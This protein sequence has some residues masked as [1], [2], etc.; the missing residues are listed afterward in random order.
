MK[1]ILGFT[2]LV[3][4]LTVSICSIESNMEANEIHK[5]A[6]TGDLNKIK[7]LTKTIRSLLI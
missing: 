5:A 2:F 1:N 7:E 3:L 6:R 4:C